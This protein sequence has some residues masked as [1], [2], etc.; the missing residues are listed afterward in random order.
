M[1]KVPF[2]FLSIQNRN[3]G[4]H[5]GATCRQW[6]AAVPGMETAGS[7]GNGERR[8]RETRSCPHL[9]LGQLVEGD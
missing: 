2:F 3:K 6:M 5:A 7:G 1:G 9:G 4:G 8:S